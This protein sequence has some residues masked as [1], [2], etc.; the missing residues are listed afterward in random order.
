MMYP[1]LEFTQAVVADRE[2]ELKRMRTV[3]KHRQ[4]RSEDG[5]PA[6]GRR[7]RIRHRRPVE[8]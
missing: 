5:R 2:R 8:A 6:G 1:S 4:A 3:R 7:R